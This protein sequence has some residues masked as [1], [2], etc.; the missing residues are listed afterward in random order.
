MKYRYT[1]TCLSVGKYNCGLVGFD[2]IFN[3]LS[4]F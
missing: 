2:S 3:F 4:D 1:G